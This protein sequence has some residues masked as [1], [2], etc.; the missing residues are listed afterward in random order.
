MEH[1]WFID[2][3]YKFLFINPYVRLSH[4]L[5]EK[6]DGAFWHDWFHDTVLAGGFNWLSRTALNEK[7]DSGF[8]DGFLVNRVLGEGTKRL[9]TRL[10]GW[11][12]GFVRYYALTVVV[13]VV[14]ILGFLLFR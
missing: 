12:N 4:F 7:V 1:K 2:E 8:I 9:S 13:G 3:A 10:R 11:Q 14:L 6:V 5:A